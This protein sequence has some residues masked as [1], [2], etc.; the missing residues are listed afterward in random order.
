VKRRLVAL[1][2]CG[3]SALAA[4]VWSLYRDLLGPSAELPSLQQADDAGCGGDTWAATRRQPFLAPFHQIQLPGLPCIDSE[5]PGLEVTIRFAVQVDSSGLVRA[6]MPPRG[7]SPSG[8]ACIRSVAAQYV[9]VPAHRC[10]GTPIAS[11]YQATLE[12]SRW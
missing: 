5:F 12:V 1:I 4:G 11:T 10:D 9:F 2:L 8:E 7:L 3:A 6:V